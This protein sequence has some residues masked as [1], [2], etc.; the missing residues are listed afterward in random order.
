L[1]GDLFRKSLCGKSIFK[2][3]EETKYTKGANWEIGVR[4]WKWMWKVFFRLLDFTSSAQVRREFKS[5][6]P[7]SFLCPRLSKKSPPSYFALSLSLPTFSSHV[8][9]HR[10]QQLIEHSKCP[11][12]M[13][14]YQA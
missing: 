11:S 3:T 6:P 1:P 2:L 14:E 10:S 12:L 4:N 7:S 5:L 9:T 8:G 13:L